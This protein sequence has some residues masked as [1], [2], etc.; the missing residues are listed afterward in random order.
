MPTL[1]EISLAI[2]S[3]KK[4]VSSNRCVSVKVNSYVF[5]LL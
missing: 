2:D 5:C 4:Q 3:I 1:E